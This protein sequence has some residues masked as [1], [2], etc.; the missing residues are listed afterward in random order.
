MAFDTSSRSLTGVG[1]PES[2]EAAEG[3]RVR[4]DA[5]NGEWFTVAGMCRDVKRANLSEARQALRVVVTGA[6][7][8]LLLAY[9]AGRGAGL[10]RTGAARGRGGTG[11]D[12]AR[13][14]RLTATRA[15][16]RRD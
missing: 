5:L 7:L 14:V 13:R 6:A 8:G 10:L 15:G 12:P 4:L 1:E 11:E 2:V 9:A 16:G 3:R